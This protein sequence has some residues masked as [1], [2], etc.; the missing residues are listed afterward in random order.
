MNTGGS[1]L[2]ELALAHADEGTLE[3]IRNSNALSTDV[4]ATEEGYFLSFRLIGSVAA[5]GISLSTSY[6]GFSP[7]AAVL[8]T[9]NADIGET[10]IG[11]L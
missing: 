4:D 10:F 8:T 2:Q 1:K 3:D 6:W 11:L 7:S 9:I 5:L